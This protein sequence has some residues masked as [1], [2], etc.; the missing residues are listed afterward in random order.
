MENE[1][2]KYVKYFTKINAHVTSMAFKG[3]KIIY[4]CIDWHIV[5]IVCTFQKYIVGKILPGAKS[6]HFH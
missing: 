6:S 4:N 3:F 1:N 5:D 2:I